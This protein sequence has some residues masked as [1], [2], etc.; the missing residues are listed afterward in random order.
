MTDELKAASVVSFEAHK[1]QKFIER[2]LLL[3]FGDPPDSEFQRGFEAG[4]AS[5]YAECL[6]GPTHDSRIAAVLDRAGFLKDSPQ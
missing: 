3:S 1:A 4:L 6:N 2:G 5:I